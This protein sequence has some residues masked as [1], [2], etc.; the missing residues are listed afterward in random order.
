MTTLNVTTIIATIIALR[1]TLLELQEMISFEGDSCEMVY[2]DW[3]PG[4]HA[5]GFVIDGK[6]TV[7]GYVWRPVQERLVDMMVP[8]RKELSV[9][10][11]RK[12]EGIEEQV[13]MGREI[14]AVSRARLF[15][16]D[17]HF[18]DGGYLGFRYQK[19]AGRR[20]ERRMA[21]KVITE[22]LLNA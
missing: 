12:A 10:E 1:N 14:K 2:G 22:Q 13:R 20:A 21:K 15:Y 6:G 5:T 19:R 17:K 9:L 4:E 8:L 11:E 3:A 7:R 16:G 18:V